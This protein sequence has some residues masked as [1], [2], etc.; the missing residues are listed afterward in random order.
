MKPFV[1][2]CV[3]QRKRAVKQGKRSSPGF[4]LIELLVVIAII[5]IL[6]GL[7]LPAVRNLQDA[8]RAAEQ[9]AKLQPVASRVLEIVDESFVATLRRAEAIFDASLANE[10]LPD[11]N[12]LTM[13]LE[14]LT[15]KGM[16]LKEARKALPELGPADD[17]NYRT[18]Y[19]NLR[20]ALDDTI[21][22]ACSDYDLRQRRSGQVCQPRF[23]AWRQT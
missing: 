21:N 9:F 1:Q 18:V 2:S 3:S 4:T 23:W 7:L 14:V 12:E 20:D 22:P 5:A 19:L 13:H 15:Q 8:A 11:T 17:A 6:I 16:A 10:T